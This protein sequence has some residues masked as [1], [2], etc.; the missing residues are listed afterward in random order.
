[1]GFPQHAECKKE[2]FCLATNDRSENTCYYSSICPN[3]EDIN[4]I[5]SERKPLLQILFYER[6]QKNKQFALLSLN[7]LLTIAESE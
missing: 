4:K 3:K 5:E 7:M 2:Q 6:L 1:M